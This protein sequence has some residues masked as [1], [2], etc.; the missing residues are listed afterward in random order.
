M[1]V[2]SYSRLN[3]TRIRNN[4]LDCRTTHVEGLPLCLPKVKSAMRASLKGGSDHLFTVL[5]WPYILSHLQ[6]TL[7][8]AHGLVPMDLDQ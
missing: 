2:C 1:T 4:G 8:Q 3:L 5:G 6:V 7:L